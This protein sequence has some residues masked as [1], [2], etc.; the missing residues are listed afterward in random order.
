MKKFMLLFLSCAFLMATD[1]FIIAHRGASA[2][3]PENTAESMILAHALNAPFVEFDLVLTKDNEAVIIHD[4]YLD[5]LSDVAQKFPKRKRKDGHYYAI[6]FT[7]AELKSLRMSEVFTDK[8]VAKFPKRFPIHSSH[9][10]ISTLEEMIELIQG[11]NKTTGKNTG[12][13]MEIKKPWFHAKEG[14][15][16]AKIVLDKLKKY[17]FKEE[18]YFSCFDLDALKR[19][20]NEL[21]AEGK[22]PLKLLFAIGQNQWKETYIQRGKKWVLFDYEPYLRGEKFEEL[23]QV[24]MGVSPSFGDLLKVDDFIS[25]AHASGLKVI[26]WTHRDDALPEWAKDSDDF[27]ETILFKEKADGIF[28][29]FVDL[30]LKFIENKK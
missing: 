23:A 24:V 25:K 14:K 17:D 5:Q 21:N 12:F 2:Y 1:K 26:T 8:N 4:L 28:T 6:D 19:I 15:D 10:S 29:D 27:F 20:K 9:F 18:L 16:I 30:G 3:L 7:L 11:L 22:L 13:F